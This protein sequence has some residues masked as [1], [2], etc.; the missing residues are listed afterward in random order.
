[1]LFSMV[2]QR[3]DHIIKNGRQWN[4]F[5]IADRTL[6]F[7]NKKA[8][9]ISGTDLT[10]IKLSAQSPDALDGSGNDAC[11]CNIYCAVIVDIGCIGSTQ[12]LNTIDM[13]G[14]SGKICNVHNAV[15]VNITLHIFARS[16]LPFKT[17]TDLGF[18]TYNS[19]C[20]DLNDCVS[21]DLRGVVSDSDTFSG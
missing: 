11:I 17:L 7:A 21:V 12:R 3:Y 20:A 15:T 4:A 16:D 10:I 14:N 8:P 18:I 6:L 2:C 9:D 5:F 1:M 19:K 13:C